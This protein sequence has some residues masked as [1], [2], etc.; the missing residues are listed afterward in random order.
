M[1]S[2][3]NRLVSSIVGLSIISSSF[4]IPQELTI[5]SQLSDVIIVGANDETSNDTTIESTESN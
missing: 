5:A 3:M 2:K 4:A 1:K